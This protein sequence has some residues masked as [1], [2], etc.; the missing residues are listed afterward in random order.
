MVLGSRLKCQP[1]LHQC[2]GLALRCLDFDSQHDFRECRSLARDRF[3]H[4]YQHVFDEHCSCVRYNI[5]HNSKLAA[6]ELPALPME[7][8][9]HGGTHLGNRKQS[10]SLHLDFDFISRKLHRQPSCHLHGFRKHDVGG[11]LH[12]RP[13][14]D[15][16]DRY[17]LH[18]LRN[19]VPDF[20]GWSLPDPASHRAC[21]L[22]I[23]KHHLRHLLFRCH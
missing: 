21:L 22:H 16:L 23:A 3:H 8:N 15:N 13:S 17:C 6:Q 11:K 9:L 14:D 2:P 5:N 10:V 4:D 1:D 12:G 7:P 18:Q 20:A 19:R